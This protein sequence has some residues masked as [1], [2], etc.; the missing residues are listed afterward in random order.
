MIHAATSSARACPQCG[1]VTDR[2]VEIHGDDA[3]KPKPGDLAVCLRCGLFETFTADGHKRTLTLEEVRAIPRVDR[4]RLER[5][6]RKI[7]KGTK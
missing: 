4:R 7:W 3:S 2:D 1:Y 6:R 5:Q